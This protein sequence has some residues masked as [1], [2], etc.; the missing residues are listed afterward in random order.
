MKK[1]WFLVPV[2]ALFFSCRTQTEQDVPAATVPPQA[3][4]FYAT[5]EGQEEDTKVFLDENLKIRWDADDRI[6]I[7]R[8]DVGNNEYRFAGVTGD[9]A[10]YFEE[11][12]TG[13]A[14]TGAAVPYN[15]AVYP[16]SSGTTLG[17]DGVLSLSLPG[18]Q[19]YREGSFGAGANTMVAVTSG[20]HLVFKNVGTFLGVCLYGADVSV[21]RITLCGKKGE[22]LSGAATVQMAPQGTPSVTMAAEG[23]STEVSVVCAEPVALG[24]DSEHATV[25][26][27]VLPPTT[28][29]E[30]FTVT[31]EDGGGHAFV[32][33]TDRSVT[34]SRNG[35]VRMAAFEVDFAGFGIY[36]ASG[37]A[38]VYDG[39]TDQMNIYEAE[40]NGWFRFLRPDLKMYELGPI[41]LDVVAGSTFSATLTATT[42]GIPEGTAEAF[43]L[44]AQSFNAGTLVLVSGAG[45]RFI[46]RF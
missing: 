27:F 32:K 20:I 5:T 34:L 42:A 33:S 39:A 8:K 16:Y 29:E 1:I 24:A 17:T 25:F 28:F 46:L 7:F 14:A 31:V 35:L 38:Y 9:N 30:G 40:G 45:D 26:W 18:E 3:E 13:A 4:V 22:K 41:P 44:T 19:S 6:S 21:S 12:W 36:P 2:W 43:S 23:T 11:A 37:E 10:G 15:Y